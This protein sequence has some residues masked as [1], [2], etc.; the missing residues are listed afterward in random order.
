MLRRCC[1]SMRGIPCSLVLRPCCQADGLPSVCAPKLCHS[2]VITVSG[3]SFDG[4]S[5]VTTSCGA[6]LC[7]TPALATKGSHRERDRVEATRWTRAPA[8]SRSPSVRAIAP[9]TATATV[10]SF[11]PAYKT[12]LK[13]LNGAPSQE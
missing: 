5:A 2:A 13:I 3:M 9:P 10:P 1:G 11:I 4:C 8:P 7:S 6:K 12:S